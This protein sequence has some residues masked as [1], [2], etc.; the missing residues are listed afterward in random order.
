MAAVSWNPVIGCTKYS[1]GCANCY[2]EPIAMRLAKQGMKA[3]R[4]GFKPTLVPERLDLPYTW[5]KPRDIFVN[6]MADI[7]H[8][9]VPAAYIGKIFTVIRQTPRH[10]YTILTKR[11]GR[12]AELAPDLD[13][14]ENLMMGVTVESDKYRARLDDLKQTPAVM[15]FICIEPLIGRLERLDFKGLD[16]VALGGESGPHARPMETDWVRDVCRWCAADG[17]PFYFKQ[18]SEYGGIPPEP[19]LDGRYFREKPMR[20]RPPDLFG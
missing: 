11:S 4:N 9:D 12:L 7:F 6:S 19:M 5:K 3:Y 14:P 2:A 1:D 20:R 18:Y 10:F 15:K 13:W 8:P 16:W 17:V